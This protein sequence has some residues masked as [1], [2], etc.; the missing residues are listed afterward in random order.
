MPTRIA[1]G[2]RPRILREGFQEEAERISPVMTNSVYIFGAGASKDFGLPLGTELF[3]YAHNLEKAPFCLTH[4]HSTS[5]PPAPPQT[6][7]YQG[8]ARFYQIGSSLG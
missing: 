6:H 8:F 4:R 7:V 3:H 2:P 1:P 5:A